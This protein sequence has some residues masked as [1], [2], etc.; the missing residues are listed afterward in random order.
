MSIS[1][2][3]KDGGILDQQ[4][5]VQEVCIRFADTHLYTASAS[6]VTVNLGEVATCACIQWID[7]SAP[8]AVLAI[9]AASRVVTSTSVAITLGAPFAADDCLIIRFVVTE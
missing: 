3:S 8:S 5:K 2:Q 4:L 9:A 1:F 7:N 6:I